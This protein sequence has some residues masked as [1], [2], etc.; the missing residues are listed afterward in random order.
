MATTEKSCND[1][2]GSHTSPEGRAEPGGPWGSLPQALEIHPAA[3]WGHL[4][5]WCDGTWEPGRE[6]P[7]LE[8]LTRSLRSDT[9]LW[10]GRGPTYLSHL[11]E[12]PRARHPVNKIP[13]RGTS[14]GQDGKPLT[15]RLSNQM[16]R[17]KCQS[18][19]VCEVEKP[20]GRALPHQ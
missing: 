5:G 16:Q 15:T 20:S 13:T 6:A 17:D 1:Q 19:H 18:E 8:A 2:Q 14:S 3:C 4:S 12:F 11:Q 7:S 10:K 9:G